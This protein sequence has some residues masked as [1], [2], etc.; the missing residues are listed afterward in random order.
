MAPVQHRRLED[1]A[2]GEE[3]AHAL[4]DQ[5]LIESDVVALVI[6]TNTRRYFP[7]ALWQ[8]QVF[9]DL[10]LLVAQ[11]IDERHRSELFGEC[12]S[13]HQAAL[14]SNAANVRLASS[15]A[16]AMSR[17][18]LLDSVRYVSVRLFMSVWNDSVASASART[19]STLM[20]EP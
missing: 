19:E 20:V 17:E 2:A 14:L 15:T 5:R 18:A 1:Q 3:L 13:A 6:V 9:L 12:N 10:H 4:L 11:F 8:V 7:A 16:S